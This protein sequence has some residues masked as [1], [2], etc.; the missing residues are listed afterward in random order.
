LNDKDIRQTQALYLLSTGGFLS[1]EGVN[2]SDLSGSLFETASSLLGII[3]SDNE[4]F[5]VG[6]NLFLKNRKGN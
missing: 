6:L 1:P 2:Q 5:K 4:K 3:K